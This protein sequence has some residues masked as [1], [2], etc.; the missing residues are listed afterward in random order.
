MSFRRVLFEF[1]AC[2]AIGA[3]IGLMIYTK[4]FTA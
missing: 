2:L 1:I 3:F 4:G